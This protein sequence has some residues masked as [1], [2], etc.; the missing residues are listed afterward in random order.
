VEAAAL[1]AEF[2]FT[3]LGTF[4]IEGRAV[5]ANGRGNG[6]LLK[7]GAS[8]EGILRGGLKRGDL[9]R[10]QFIWGLLAEEWR[11]QPVGHRPFSADAA[12]KNIEA[13]IAEFQTRLPNP[14]RGQQPSQSALRAPLYPFFVSSPAVDSPDAPHPPK[15]K[16]PDES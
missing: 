1:V 11:K 2:A 3:T 15:L 5:T 10:D 14:P 4:R 9:P 12:L 16:P 13:A 8:S 6:A 7:L